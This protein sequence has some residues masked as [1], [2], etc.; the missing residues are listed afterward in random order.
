[1]YWMP[2]GW[3]LCPQ[4]PGLE[5]HSGEGYGIAPETLGSSYGQPYVARAPVVIAACRK[6][7]EEA[8]GHTLTGVTQKF[9]I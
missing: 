5:V 9:F 2:G 6:A 3:P 1:V 4:P 7:Q 8:L